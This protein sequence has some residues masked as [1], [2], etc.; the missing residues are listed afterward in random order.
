MELRNKCSP[1]INTAVEMVPGSSTSSD[2]KYY[3]LTTKKTG[4]F[5]SDEALLQG[6]NKQ[7]RDY[8]YSRLDAPP[9]PPRVKLLLRLGQINDEDGEG[10]ESS[11]A[12]Q[13]EIRRNCALVNH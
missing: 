5:H 13:G 3:D 2:T 1:G 10:S 12:M 11:Q 7:T 6:K 4:L 9:P 8:V